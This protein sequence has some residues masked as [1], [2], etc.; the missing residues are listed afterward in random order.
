MFGCF[1]FVS[2]SCSVVL[3]IVVLCCVVLF[4]V[5]VLVEVYSYLVVLVFV[6]SLK[7]LQK[8]LKIAK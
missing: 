4:S 6:A 3:C 2:V 1:V 8:R 7:I 5:V